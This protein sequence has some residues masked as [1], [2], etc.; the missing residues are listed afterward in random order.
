M[1]LPIAMIHEDSRLLS[2]CATLSRPSLRTT[3]VRPHAQLLCQSAILL[4]P[5]PFFIEMN[6]AFT[7]RSRIRFL[8]LLLPLKGVHDVHGI[9]GMIPQRDLLLL[10]ERDRLTSLFDD[11]TPAA[12]APSYARAGGPTVWSLGRVSNGLESG[13]GYHEPDGR[14]TGLELFTLFDGVYDDGTRMPCRMMMPQ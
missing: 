1:V 2:L 4:I 11:T 3:N 10:Y 6:R 12:N 5:R 13:R 9:S 8:F 7:S 14:P